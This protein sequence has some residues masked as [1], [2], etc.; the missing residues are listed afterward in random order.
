MTYS[1]RNLSKQL[2][3]IRWEKTPNEKEREQFLHEVKRTLENAESPIYFISDLRRGR[4]S[5][6]QTIR[7]LIQ[8]LEHKNYAGS[9]SFSSDT[10]TKLIAGVFT[11]LANTEGMRDKDCETL[12]EAM[13]FLES[14]S[15]GLTKDIDWESVLLA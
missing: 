8:I 5:D 10:R 3:L 15:A 7:Q 12:E 11:K 13:G 4:I 14:L 2:V 9:V 1:F 6:L